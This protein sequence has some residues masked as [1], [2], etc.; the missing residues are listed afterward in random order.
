MDEATKTDLR[1]AL[2]RAAATG[3]L[4][5]LCDLLDR[6]TTKRD[7]EWTLKLGITDRVLTPE[8]F[9]VW[10]RNDRVTR[11]R[12]VTDARPRRGPIRY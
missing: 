10:L 2:S 7:R 11:A 4:E 1:Y 5:A 12:N 6:L 9:E 3:S 8:E